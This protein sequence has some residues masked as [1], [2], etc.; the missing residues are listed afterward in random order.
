MIRSRTPLTPIVP[1]SLSSAC[2]LAAL[3]TVILLPVLLLL[4]PPPLCIAGVVGPALGIVAAAS[5]ICTPV[6]LLI[7]V[8]PTAI[9]LL[10]L[11]VLLPRIGKGPPLHVGP[12]PAIP[13]APARRTLV[14]MF[15]FKAAAAVP[16]RPPSLLLLLLPATLGAP[17]P[18]GLLMGGPPGLLRGPPGLLMRGPPEIGR[19]H[20]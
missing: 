4:L 13:K 19:A 6:C 1:L 18:P 2:I 3:P 11:R 15:S 8:M 9:A 7:P 14:R 12:L 20:V 5:G 10:L 16:S 17:R